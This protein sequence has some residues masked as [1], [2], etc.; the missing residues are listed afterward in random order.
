[1]SERLSFGITFLE[2][3]LGIIMAAIGA[4]LT[5]YT[6]TGPDIP[7]IASFFFLAAGIILV[8]IGIILVIAKTG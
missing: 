8:I 2:K 1:M 4:L 5:Y 3:L 7:A 6:Y